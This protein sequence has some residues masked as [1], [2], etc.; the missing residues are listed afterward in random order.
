MVER[1]AAVRIEDE[2]LFVVKSETESSTMGEK[3][4]VDSDKQANKERLSEFSYVEE[5]HD[6]FE[7]G[8]MLLAMRS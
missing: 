4:P 1:V 6:E 3:T 8:L 2:D 7:R 5:R